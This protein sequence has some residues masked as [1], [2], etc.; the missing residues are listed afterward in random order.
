MVNNAKIGQKI[1]AIWQEWCVSGEVKEIH[2]DNAG[3]VTAYRWHGLYY[4][5]ADGKE[6]D[7]RFYGEAGSTVEDTFLTGPEARQA[8]VKRSD[9][10]YDSYCREI[11]TVED[12]V[13]FPLHHCL[14]GEDAEEEARRAYEKR[15]KDILNMEAK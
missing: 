15:L 5:D 6:T 4:L 10:L 2:T 13:N 11:K 12:L 3:N 7:N 9:D 1:Y 14:T 8:A